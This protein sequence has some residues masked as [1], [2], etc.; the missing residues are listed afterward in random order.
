[1]RR[2]ADNNPQYRDDGDSIRHE[3][4]IVRKHAWQIDK[5]PI[6][7][8][9]LDGSELSIPWRIGQNWEVR[10]FVLLRWKRY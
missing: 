10:P 4:N 2:Q 5:K 8:K 6:C 7:L 9:Y 3:H 1:M